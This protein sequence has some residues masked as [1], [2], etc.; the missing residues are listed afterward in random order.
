MAILWYALVPLVGAIIRRREWHVFRGRF[1]E[2]RLHPILDYRS[3][4]QQGKDGQAERC[5]PGG[6]NAFRYVGGFESVT[7]RQ[8]LWIRGD[9]LTV[10]VSLKNAKTYLLPMQEN[11]DDVE[12]FDPGVESPQ[13]ISWERV[14]ALTEGARVFVG[15][16]LALRDGRWSFVSTKEHPLIVIFFD[17]PDN[18]LASTVIKAGRHRGEYWNSLTPYSLI[19]GAAFQILMAVSFIPRPAFRLTVVVAFIALFIPLYPI[20][21]PGLLFTIVY[22]RIAWKA[23]L[24]RIYAGLAL[25]PLRYLASPKGSSSPKGED[26]IMP[27][28]LLP[29]GER[30]GCIRSAELPAQAREGNIPLLLPDSAKPRAG[31]PWLVFGALRDGEEMP[32]QP[33]DPFATFG[34]LPG[35]PQAFTRRFLAGA[36]ALEALAW[37]MLLA[38]I[39]LNIFFLWM[40]MALL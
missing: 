10:P 12:A 32:C 3:Y 1:D 5:P 26:E 21:P 13:K 29:N 39:G 20:I 2:L 19:V 40:V 37:L 8:T 31:D 22:R 11:A 38:G 23:R 35:R 34:I 17:G 25:L 16:L 6:H 18:T 9:D 24:L 4:W 33:A 36:Y 7:D 15:G 30:Y 14:S 27:E 28:C